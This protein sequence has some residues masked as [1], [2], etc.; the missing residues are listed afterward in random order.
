MV[1]ITFVDLGPTAHVHL[2]VLAPRPLP[3]G[4]WSWG[5]LPGFAG[6]V[7]KEYAY[8][9]REC[10]SLVQTYGRTITR[11][12]TSRQIGDRFR[13]YAR[14]RSTGNM[15]GMREWV[16]SPVRHDF[17]P[18]GEY[19]CGWREA[20]QAYYRLTGQVFSEKRFEARP[21]MSA[22]PTLVPLPS[23]CPLASAA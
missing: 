16:W 5:E 23:R 20:I 22:A 7:A 10:R 8:S 17:E 11:V 3:D 21:L 1:M 19:L 13:V 4:G 6:V 12:L 9:A 2:Y 18:V 15:L 14:G